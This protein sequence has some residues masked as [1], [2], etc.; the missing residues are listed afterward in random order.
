MFSVETIKAEDLSALASLYS[1]LAGSVVKPEGMERVFAAIDV[2]PDYY[3]FG[4][5]SDTGVLAGSVMGI[6]CMDLCFDERPF[7]IMENMIVGSAWQGRGVGR[8]LMETLEKTAEERNCVFIEFCSSWFRTGAHRFYE[9]LGYDPG[10]V[11]GY[12]KFL[13]GS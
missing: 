1:E 3:L 7:M 2:S 12:R 10:M 6:V 11:K 9:S 13:T 4:A 8:L 5:R